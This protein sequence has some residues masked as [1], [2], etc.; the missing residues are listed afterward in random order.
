M[1][2]SKLGMILGVFPRFLEIY[3]LVIS[4]TV[5]MLIGILNVFDAFGEK[6]PVC[7]RDI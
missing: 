3:S 1:D 2:D 7:L 5:L 6:A 4:C